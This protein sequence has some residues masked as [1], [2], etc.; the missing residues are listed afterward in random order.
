MSEKDKKPKLSE[1]LGLFEEKFLQVLA[2]LS[3]SIKKY[4]LK[5][6]DAAKL[7]ELQELA[8]K[9]PSKI[10][11]LS[12][13]YD[14]LQ[15]WDI[16]NSLA[17]VAKYARENNLTKEGDHLD[18]L[19]C[20]LYMYMGRCDLPNEL[21]IV[22]LEDERWETKRV[23]KCN[24]VL[25]YILQ[26]YRTR[27][28]FARIVKVVGNSYERVARGTLEAME[29]KLS[30][31]GEKQFFKRGDI[32]VVDR[33]A[34]EIDS[35]SQLFKEKFGKELELAI[36]LP[37]YAHFGICAGPDEIIHFAGKSDM[38]GKKTI[39]SSTV[40]GFLNCVRTKQTDKEIYIVHCPGPG[41]R[42]YKLFPDTSRIG[43]NVAH[44]EIWDC[45]DYE[46]L[47]WYDASTTIK[48]ARE[49]AEASAAGKDKEYS[50]IS[51]NC[52]DFAFYCKTGMYLSQQAEN[53]ENAGKV[54]LKFFTKESWMP[55]FLA[56]DALKSVFKSLKEREA[57][58]MEDCEENK[59]SH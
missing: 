13:K 43:F 2:E 54:L 7:K 40:R 36:P 15:I 53:V 10:S 35:L 21:V 22:N 29:E 39:H 24:P 16:V 25:S 18:M 34:Y 20:M 30:R 47:G 44:V 42:P 19:M 28:S 48:R 3:K 31:L 58:D 4:D 51:Y 9:T 23:K 14:W 11:E 45:I 8:K 46:K 56:Y 55:L 32:V 49:K 33:G 57:R 12:S 26:T 17:D 52:E 59:K 37:L 27:D 41:K 6:D 38:L 5:L 50:I 1:A